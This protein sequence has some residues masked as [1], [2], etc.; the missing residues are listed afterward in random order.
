MSLLCVM[1]L[2][3]RLCGRYEWRARSQRCGAQSIPTREI[4]VMWLV[5][6]LGG[7]PGGLLAESVH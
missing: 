2:A 6:R 4:C 5:A 3:M 1:W 7:H